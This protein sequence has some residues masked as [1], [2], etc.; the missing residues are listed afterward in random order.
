MNKIVCVCERMDIYVDNV[1]FCG[2]S[3]GLGL[4]GIEILEV[5]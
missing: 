3:L 2:L 5:D 1:H 4:L